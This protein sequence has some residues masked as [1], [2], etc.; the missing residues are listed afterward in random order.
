M[1]KKVSLRAEV[2]TKLK[3]WISKMKACFSDKNAHY[4]LLNTY[5]F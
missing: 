4:K 5:R 2:Q 1:H 3:N